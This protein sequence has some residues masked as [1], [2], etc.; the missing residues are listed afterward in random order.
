MEV[1]RGQGVVD[2]AFGHVGAVDTNRQ[3][4][5]DSHHE[6]GNRH[7]SPCSTAAHPEKP[8]RLE[9]PDET[10]EHGNQSHIHERD[11]DRSVP[12]ISSSF[13]CR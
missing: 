12:L 9:K 2:T 8:K 4:T 1:I 6:P 13:S 5:D 10:N 7:D 3:R 11:G